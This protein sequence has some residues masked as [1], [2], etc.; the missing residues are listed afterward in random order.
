MARQRDN[1]DSVPDDFI[2]KNA[3]ENPVIN[4]PYEEPQSHWVYRGSVPEKIPLRRP[5][6]YWYQSRRTG[7]LETEDLFA[8]E[9]S[10][11]LPLVNALREDVGRWQIGRAHV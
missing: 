5:A 11:D 4:K 8:E 10:D 1:D 2:P 6:Q 3:V 7:A 9:Q